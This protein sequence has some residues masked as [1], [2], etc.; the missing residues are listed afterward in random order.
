MVVNFCGGFVECD[1]NIQ[2][3]ILR[4]L[5]DYFE[6]RDERNHTNHAL[7][8]EKEYNSDTIKKMISQSL[9]DV[10]HFCNKVHPL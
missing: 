1:E 7:R 5:K 8:R 2:S 3:N 9:D 10:E 4:I 6:I